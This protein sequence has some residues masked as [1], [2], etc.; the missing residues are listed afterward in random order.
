MLR[1]SLL[2]IMV[3]AFMALTLAACSGGGGGGDRQEPSAKYDATGAW[4][5]EPQN[6]STECDGSNDYKDACEQSGRIL[7][8]ELSKLEQVSIV[9]TGIKFSI[10]MEDE[11]YTGEVDYKT[12]TFSGK[13]ENTVDGIKVIIKWYATINLENADYFTG[14]I[15]YDI[16]AE[17]LY[18]YVNVSIQGWREGVFDPI[19]KIEPGTY[20]DFGVVAYTDSVSVEFTVTNIGH[21]EFAECLHLI[22]NGFSDSTYFRWDWETSDSIHCIPRGESF[23]FTIIYEPQTWGEEHFSTFTFETNDP[24]MPELV[25]ELTGTSTTELPVVSV[26]V[27]DECEGSDPGIYMCFEDREMCTGESEPK[28]ITFTNDGDIELEISLA[29]NRYNKCNWSLYN[30][31]SERIG[32][33]SIDWNILL[34]PGES[35]E[36]TIT[37]HPTQDS[38]HW[39]CFNFLTNDPNYEEILIRPKGSGTY[40]VGVSCNEYCDYD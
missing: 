25:I 37:F 14:V 8:E 13:E 11:K 2:L 40:V 28:T 30:Q 15:E 12:Y 39:E 22:K 18:C 19:L 3:V 4:L 29:F 10:T 7:F 31:F 27:E 6:Y 17:D 24:N 35:V 21:P 9:Q 38:A 20:H 34:Q 33:D 23:K 36:L 5:F 1:R 26:V 16:Y 32:V